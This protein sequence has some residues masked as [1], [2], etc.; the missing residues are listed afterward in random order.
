M[1]V[2]EPNGAWQVKQVAA[3]ALPASPV[4][5]MKVRIRAKITR[6]DLVCIFEVF[7]PDSFKII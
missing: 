2:A 3:S 7:M 5:L 1:S 6:K 4:R